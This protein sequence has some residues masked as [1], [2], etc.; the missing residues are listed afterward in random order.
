MSESKHTPGPWD[1][2]GRL[3]ALNRELLAALKRT[4]RALKEL[5]PEHRI[6]RDAETA[7]RKATGQD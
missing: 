4:T 7:I 2:I 1:E 6:V 5:N 3:K